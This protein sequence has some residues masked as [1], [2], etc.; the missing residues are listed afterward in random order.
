MQITR[1][2]KEFVKIGKYQDLHVQSD[3]LLLVYVIDNSQNTLLKVCELEPACFF[4]APE[5]A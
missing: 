4:T 2:Q 3:T 1:M 5:V